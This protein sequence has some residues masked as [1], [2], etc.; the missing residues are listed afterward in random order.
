MGELIP[1]ASVDGV[2]ELRFPQSAF[3]VVALQKAALKYSDQLSVQWQDSGT[4]WVC[5]LCR[6]PTADTELSTLA[7]WFSTEVLDQQLRDRIANET[8]TERNLIL[9]H[10]FSRSKLV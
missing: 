5:R 1:T 7:Q 3:S 8:A 6:T 2:F 4:E 10:T 9:A